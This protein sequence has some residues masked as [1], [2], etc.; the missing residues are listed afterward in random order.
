MHGSSCRRAA[1]SKKGKKRKKLSC[2][3]G[4]ELTSTPARNA[5][6]EEFEIGLPVF[7]IKI[8]AG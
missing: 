3:I 7:Y 5:S 4:D 8:S 1:S 6:V 2:G